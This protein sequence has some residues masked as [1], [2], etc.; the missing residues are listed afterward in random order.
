MSRLT[1]DAG[2]RVLLLEAGGWDRDPW[3]RI[4]LGWGR[5]L[6]NRLQRH[7]GLT[8]QGMGQQPKHAALPENSHRGGVLTM[9][10]VLAVS[11]Y[12]QRTSPVLRGKWI[13]ETILGTPAPP[14]H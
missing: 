3:I 11:S 12:P 8:V 9:A 5:I 14:P 1:E 4:P 2:C 6:T 7:Y 13:L 10:A